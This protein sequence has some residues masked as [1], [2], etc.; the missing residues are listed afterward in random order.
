MLKKGINFSLG[1]V[2]ILL[3]VWNIIAALSG[4]GILPFMIIFNL[5]FIVGYFMTK[6]KSKPEESS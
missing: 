3:T 5:I 4:G 2:A 1:L 6:N